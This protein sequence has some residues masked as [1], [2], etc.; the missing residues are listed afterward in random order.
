[1]P[2]HIR[3]KKTYHGVGEYIGRPSVLGNPFTHIPSGTKAQ[4]VVAS[5]GIAVESYRGWLRE[6]WRENGPERAELERLVRKYK[7]DGELVLVCWC[8]PEACHGDVLKEVIEI[9]ASK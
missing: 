3:N 4:Y 7:A 8:H 1:M 5:R 9:L 6:K 2:I